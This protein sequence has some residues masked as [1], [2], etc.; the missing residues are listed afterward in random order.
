MD[1]HALSLNGHAVGV[2]DMSDCE[3]LGSLNPVDTRLRAQRLSKWRGSPVPQGQ[4]AGHR[5]FSRLMRRGAEHVVE[6]ER[7]YTPVNVTGR[8]LV[9]GAENEVRVH[10][11]VDVIVNDQGR[12]DR[13]AFA[14]DHVAQR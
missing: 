12:R 4:G 13:I 6:D 10:R 7:A 3:Y 2:S 14:D 11:A 9:R 1:E 8:S 5:R